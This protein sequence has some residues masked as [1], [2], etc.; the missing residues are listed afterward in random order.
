M[1]QVD[2]GRISGTVADTSGA[3]IPGVT[4]QVRN[5]KTGDV[6]NVTSA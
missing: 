1:A 3:L 2:Q 6:R 4:L 5:Q